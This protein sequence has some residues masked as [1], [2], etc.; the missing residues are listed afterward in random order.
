ML[1]RACARPLREP[2]ESLN[3]ALILQPQY[4]LNT[5]LVAQA[6]GVLFGVTVLFVSVV[7]PLTFLYIQRYKNKINGPWDEVFCPFLCLFRCLWV[8]CGWWLKASYIWNLMPHTL[9]ASSLYNSV[10][11]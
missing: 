3:T 5:A 1:W 7:C 9:V 10:L 2:N 11:F 4:S 8:S 6:L